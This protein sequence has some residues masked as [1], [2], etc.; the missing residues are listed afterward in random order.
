MKYSAVRII[1][2]ILAYIGAAFFIAAAAYGIFWLIED[3]KSRKKSRD[4]RNAE[5]QRRLENEWAKKYRQEFE[6]YYREQGLLMDQPLKEQKRD[7]NEG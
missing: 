2:I 3:M 4:L 5:T 1:T 6:R 7:G